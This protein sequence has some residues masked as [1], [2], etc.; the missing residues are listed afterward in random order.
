MSVTRMINELKAENKRLKERNRVLEEV[1][2]YYADEKTYTW[3]IPKGIIQCLSNR[4]Y[5]FSDGG[6]KAREAKE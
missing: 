5:M 1:R 3:D 2:A 6:K 4:I